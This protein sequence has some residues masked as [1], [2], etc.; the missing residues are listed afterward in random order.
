M[1]SKGEI[2]ISSTRYYFETYEI[3]KS[4]CYLHPGLYIHITVDSF[5][6]SFGMTA[7]LLALEHAERS[8]KPL[9]HD[10]SD[11]LGKFYHL[12]SLEVALS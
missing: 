12:F 8:V 7:A 10:Q 2:T 4:L 11:V 1:R 6:Q 3:Q 5:R 9:I